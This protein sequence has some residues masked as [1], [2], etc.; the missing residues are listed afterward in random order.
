M[1]GFYTL[2]NFPNCCSA[3]DGKHIIFCPSKIG[4]EFYNYKKDYSVIL[5]AIVD[6]NYK[7]IYIDVG[8]NG[9]VNDALVFSKSTF[10]EALQTNTLNLPTEGV[11]VGNDAFPL[12]KNIMKPYSMK[13]P[14]T[15]K[16]R[17]FNYV[18]SRAGRVSENAFGIMIS[19][20]QVYVKL[21]PLQLHKVDQLIK[22][23]CVLHNWLGQSTMSTFPGVTDRMLDIEDWEEGRIIPGGWRL[24]K[25]EG[26]KNATFLHSNTYR[27]NASDVRDKYAEM[28]CSSEVVP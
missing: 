3:M 15:V 13:R 14:L 12:R 19:R 27:I 17:I 26:M 7:F 1:Q 21:I 5:L 9:R 18:L 4:S 23:T 25:A 20:F 10:N 24:V 28:F 6:A 11:F 16:D 8:T 22:V 2:W